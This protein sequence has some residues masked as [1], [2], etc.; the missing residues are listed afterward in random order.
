MNTEIQKLVI[1]NFPDLKGDKVSGQQ[2]TTPVSTAPPSADEEEDPSAES[3]VSD[4][5]RHAAG[6]GDLPGARWM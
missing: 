2:R 4:G 1:S 5:V 3:P 6:D